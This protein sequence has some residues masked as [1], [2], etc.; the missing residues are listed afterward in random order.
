MTGPPA[1]VYTDLF[2]GEGRLTTVGAVDFKGAKI[3]FDGAFVTYEPNKAMRVLLGKQGFRLPI[4]AIRF[5]EYRPPALMRV[6]Y[7]RVNTGEPPLDEASDAPRDQHSFHFEGK[8][9]VAAVEALKDEIERAIA[10]GE[11]SAS[12]TPQTD[13]HAAVLSQLAQLRDQGI[14]SDEEYLAKKAEVLARI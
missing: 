4:S 12:A 9:P 5:L 10:G 7:L 6:G 11:T 3:S 2:W 13:S 1:T 8:K 14:L